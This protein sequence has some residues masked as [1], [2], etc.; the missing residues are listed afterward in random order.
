MKIEDDYHKVCR[1]KHELL[2]P[3]WTN[4]VY[5][6]N[7]VASNN[8]VLKHTSKTAAPHTCLPV[9]LALT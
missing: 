4:M 7:K 1:E 3:T 9:H 5:V 6:S 8:T 2:S